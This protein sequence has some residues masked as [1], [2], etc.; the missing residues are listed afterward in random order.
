MT[1]KQITLRQALSLV[2]FEHSDEFGWQV[3]NVLDDVVGTVYGTVYCDVNGTVCGTINGREWDFIETHEE[4][5]RRLLSET[6]NQEL[7]DAFNQM[8]NN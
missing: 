5:F 4:K 7:I 1:G 6:E 3:K 2:E 8:E